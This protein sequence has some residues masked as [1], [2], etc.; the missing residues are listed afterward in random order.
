[1]VMLLALAISSF[2]RNNGSALNGQITIIRVKA[3][4]FAI[5]VRTL[6]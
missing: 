1:M 2:S 5:N 6:R 4:I 3:H